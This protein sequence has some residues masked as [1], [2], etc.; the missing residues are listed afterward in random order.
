[1]HYCNRRATHYAGLRT[2][3]D[4]VRYHH[5]DYNKLETLRLESL[6]RRK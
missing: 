6:G 3:P 2:A 5:P 1:M 4:R